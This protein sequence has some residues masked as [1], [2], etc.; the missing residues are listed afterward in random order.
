MF[1][2]QQI[3]SSW[4]GTYG[5][6]II[7][8]T[9]S[10]NEPNSNGKDNRFEFCS[11]PEIKGWER[12]VFRLD[13]D[14]KKVLSALSND[15][16][17]GEAIKKYPGLRL[18]RQEPHQCFFS[19]ACASNSNITMIRR[20]LLNLSKKFGAKLIFDGNEFYTF[21]SVKS[22]NKATLGELQ[23]CGVGY[24]AK[25]IKAVAEHLTC[26]NLDINSLIRSE[27]EEAKEEIL[28]VY[29]LGNKIADCILL[30]S[31]EKLEAFP[32]DVWI[33]KAISRYYYWL[34]EQ[35]DYSNLNKLSTSDSLSGSQYRVI[36]QFLRRY[37]GKYSGYAQQFIYYHMREM[38]GK[39]W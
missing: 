15:A 14:I 31:L 17:V 11:Y 4:Y 21:P 16:L 35:N 10:N 36:S 2:W 6:H 23:S 12:S 39:T 20:M 19:F 9:L 24:R 3:G 30:F 13:D 25:T 18:M 37:F 34:L 38:A 22:L 7:K 5:D 27:Y 1:L 26:G 28:K 29:G 8:F 32:I 33:F